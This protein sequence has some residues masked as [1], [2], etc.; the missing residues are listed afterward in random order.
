MG[1]ILLVGDKVVRTNP[2]YQPLAY[3]SFANFNRP[4]GFSVL[5][6]KVRIS[7]APP[8]SSV[9]TSWSPATAVDAIRAPFG[10]TAVTSGD[11][12]AELPP[13]WKRR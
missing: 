5:A 3:G 13:E 7:V 10:S 8:I 11:A 2:S 4:V 6:S 9:I 1:K 12:A